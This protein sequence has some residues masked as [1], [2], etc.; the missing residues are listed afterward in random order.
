MLTKK[1]HHRISTT[2]MEVTHKRNLK[3][4]LWEAV[5]LLLSKV[6]T[7]DVFKLII[8]MHSS[9]LLPCV[10]WSSG[11][12]P[13]TRK[14]PERS[15]HFLRS[16]LLETQNLT[17]DSEA[18]IFSAWT[19]FILPE[20]DKRYLPINDYQDRRWWPNGWHKEVVDVESC[21]QIPLVWF[22]HQLMSNLISTTL[23]IHSTFLLHLW[24]S[25]SLMYLQT[26]PQWTHVP[27]PTWDEVN[28]E[29]PHKKSN[30]TRGLWFKKAWEEKE[31]LLYEKNHT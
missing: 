9:A 28:L 11:D 13:L 1:I 24:T 3:T 20:S 18:H 30:G 14:R 4:Y 31:Q 25:G 10:Q 29:H 19:M 7:S 16:S 26:L 5:R 2:I 21:T 23:P 8:S 12:T 6:I 15:S 17:G 22:F 27:M